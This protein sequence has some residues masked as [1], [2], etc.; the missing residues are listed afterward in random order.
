MGIFFLCFTETSV[1][2]RLT[3]SA[4]GNFLFYCQGWISRRLWPC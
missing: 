1:I 2:S 3:I 4:I